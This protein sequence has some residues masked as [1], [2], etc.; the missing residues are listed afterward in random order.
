[1]GAME[2]ITAQEQFGLMR[3]GAM[4]VA[5]PIGGIREVVPY[6]AQLAAMP[7]TMPELLGS[8][9]LRGA[10]VP[11]V[12]LA[13]LLGRTPCAADEPAGIIMVMRVQDRVIGAGM[14][15]I[16]GVVTLCE[17][18]RTALTI[19]P[20]GGMAAGGLIEGG[21]VCEGKSGVILRAAAFADLP[22]IIMAQDRL[23]AATEASQRGAPSLA[24]TAGTFR[25]GIPAAIIEA[26]IPARP[27]LPSPV[28][29][30]LWLARVEYNG[31]CIPVIDTLALLG[32]GSFGPA[33]EMA[34]VLLRMGDGRRVALRIDGVLDMI[35]I[36]PAQIARMQGFRFGQD[37][38]IGGMLPSAHPVLLLDPDALIAHAGL[39]RLSTLEEKAQD[40][41]LGGHGASEA[42][43]KGQIGGEP[44]LIFMLGDGH[45]AVPLRQVTEIMNHASC[46]LVGLEQAFGPCQAILSHRG[47][48]IPVLDLSAHLR[49]PPCTAPAFLLLVSDGE[50][51]AAFPLQDLCAVERLV[52]RPVGNK[53]GAMAGAMGAVVRTSEGRTCSV[54][55]LAELI[56]PAI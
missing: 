16:C 17:A 5:L 1:M 9:D 52:A 25:F 42:S 22:G 49:L 19:P 3:I 51:T 10:L 11:V 6:P 54:L 39:Q 40:F 14:H 35:R 18:Q 56:P 28:E 34:C 8:I 38:L 24:V 15:E 55:D 7:P 32:L 12:D 36:A 30:G 53:G 2:S 44:Y 45:H 21:F 37:G 26:T 41:R 31:A 23:V 43:G 48:A 46:S 13:A 29:D 50:R 27:V 4:Y 33:R 47:M 20:G